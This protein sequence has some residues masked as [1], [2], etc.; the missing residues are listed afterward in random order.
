MFDNM[1]TEKIC[2][3]LQCGICLETSTLPVHSTCCNKSKSMNPGCLNCVRKYYELNKKPSMRTS[4]KK[5]WTGCGCN[6]YPGYCIKGRLPYE[7]T[8]QLDMIRNMIGKSKCH[9]DECNAE[10]DTC[11][12]LRRHLLGE[13]TETDKFGNCRYS[14]TKCTKCNFHG[15][16]WYVEGPHNKLYH[17]LIWCIICNKYIN[18]DVMKSHYDKHKLDLKA[19]KNTITTFLETE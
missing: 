18:I 5:S 17:S 6:I 8:Y 7:H 4:E 11:A 14:I 10:F 16:R 19:F 13:S 9:H 2:E 12:E 3:M 1:T 15:K